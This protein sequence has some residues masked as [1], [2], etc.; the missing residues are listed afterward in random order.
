[1]PSRPPGRPRYDGAVP[2]LTRPSRSLRAIAALL[3]ALAASPAAAQ[4]QADAIVNEAFD[5]SYNL[6]H[7]PAIA[8]LTE[9]AK[10]YPQHAGIQRALATMTWLHLLFNRGAVLVDDYLGPVSRQNVKIEPPPAEVSKAFHTYLARA[11]TLADRARREGAAGSRRALRAGHGAGAAG[12]LERDDRRPG[13][14]GVRRGAARLQRARA[15]AGAG[16][17][18]QGRRPD[19]RHLP[20]SDCESVDAGAVD[21]LCGGLRRRPRARAADDRRRHHHGEHANRCPVRTRITVQPRASVG[22]RDE[23][24]ASA[25]DLASA[26]SSRVARSEVRRSFAPGASP[27]PT[28]C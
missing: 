24:L 5:L 28:P 23:A 20:L 22:P 8:K 7:D 11:L 19:R 2:S 1:M 10:H 14:G 21:G 3:V 26:Q 15:G 16:A 13:D 25:A 12:L 27:K 9:A 4:P 18:P 6:D 17:G